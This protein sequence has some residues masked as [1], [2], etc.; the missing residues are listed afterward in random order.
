MNRQRFLLPALLALTVARLLFLPLH[1]LS[2]VEQ[3]VVQCSQ[4]EGLWQPAVGP[5]LP[6]LVKASTTVFGVHPFGVRFLAPFLM[7]GA[8][9]LVWQV[10]RGMFDATTASWA[11][12]LFQVT[13][14]VNVASVTMTFTTLGIASSAV[15]LLALRLALHR[16]YRWHL[17]W[18]LL[19]GALV[20]AMAVDWR[21]FMLAVSCVAG[22]ALTQRGRRALLKWPVLP[23]LGSCVGLA[24]TFFLA[25]NS[26][27]GWP[28]FAPFPFMVPLALWQL[29]V[30][31]LLAVSPLLLAGFGW[32][33]ARSVTKQ[34]ME[35]AVAFLYAFVW[36]LVTLDVLS[37]MVL[38]WPQCGL[39]AWIG[40]A[41]MLLAHHAMT[42]DKA[43]TRR[44]ILARW[45]ALAAAAIQSCLM[46][47]RGLD[48][49]P[50]LPW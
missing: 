31:V 36:P 37:W 30:H 14:A 33:L 11:L 8:G 1:E 21:L 32:S 18:W 16:E 2:M 47:S 23:I 41:A 43:P 24:M 44:A 42:H 40:P 10:S 27:H 48:H 7:L 15:L 4:R 38:P 26:E 45:L 29:A 12:V 50:G 39:G 9:Y 17:Q 20:L 5:V 49:L 13:P 46:L 28:A 25:W 3:H 19:A 34:P 35:Y 22:M 6:L